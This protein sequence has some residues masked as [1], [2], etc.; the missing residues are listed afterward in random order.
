MSL[1]EEQFVEK[2]DKKEKYR[3][4]VNYWNNIKM[5]EPK[6]LS[7]ISQVFPH[8]TMHDV[9]HSIAILDSIE[10]FLGP[11]IITKLSVTDLW[12]LLCST[13]SHDI[14]MYI[15]GD[16][17]QKCFDSEEFHQFVLKQK[18]DT[19]SPLNKYAVFYDVDDNNKLRYNNC[20]LSL[21][22][23][24]SARFLL[25]EY[26]RNK[27]A[28]RSKNFIDSG[29]SVNQMY[30]EIKRLISITAE[31]CRLHSADFSEVMKFYDLENGIGDYCHPRFVTCML[32]IGDLLD[33]DS[34]RVSWFLLKHLSSS[35]PENSLTH[36]EKNFNVVHALVTPEKVD[37]FAECTDCNVA[38]EMDK[39]FSWI[40][41]E[42]SN[43]RNS[44]N[45]ISPVPEAKGYPMLG[46]L[47][48]KLIG[49]Y[50]AIDNNFKPKFEIDDE[51]AIKILQGSGLYSNK[52]DCI[53]EI[54]QNAV[55]A[56]YLRI[57]LER[58]NEFAE[59]KLDEGFKAFL[60][61]CKQPE[62]QIEVRCKK[63]E[64]EEIN[65]KEE[66]VN[67]DKKKK[68]V[69]HFE[70][71]DHGI[72]LRKSDLKYLLKI[73]SGKNNKDKFDIIKKMPEYAKPSGIF[74][75]GFQSIFLIAE[76]VNIKSRYA[77]SDEVIDV[78]VGTPLK[79]GFALLKTKKNSFAD[80]GTL[81][82]FDLMENISNDETYLRYDSYYNCFKESYDFLR[83][84]KC[85]LEI[86]RILNAV[87]KVVESSYLKI[88]C[89]GDGV[90]DV[91]EK[92]EKRKYKSIYEDEKENLIVEISLNCEKRLLRLGDGIFVNEGINLLYR[93]EAVIDHELSEY[94]KFL[95]LNINILSGNS[96]EILS[97]SRN[98]LK[99][100]YANRVKESIIKIII[101]WLVK[102][103]D[104][105]NS[106]DKKIAAL[107][108]EYYGKEGEYEEKRK[109]W[110]KYKI[111]DIT[112]GKKLKY[113]SI[114]IVSD[115]YYA[116]K[117]EGKNNDPKQKI[118]EYTFYSEE[119]QFLGYVLKKYYKY[120]MHY[121]Q[122]PKKNGV[123]DGSCVAIEFKKDSKDSIDWEYWLRE[124]RRRKCRS[125][126][127]CYDYKKIEVKDINCL[128]RHSDPMNLFE[129]V[130]YPKTVCPYV[131]KDD[132]L[133]WDCSDKV[134]QW[135]RENNI[136]DKVTEDEI[137][138]EY[139]KMR[140]D[141]EKI[142]K[143]LNDE[144]DKKKAK[145]EKDKEK[146]EAKLK[147]S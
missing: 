52:F 41:D 58:M 142:V 55:D 99:I 126:M 144:V 33:F 104:E 14:G 102:Y 97:V 87:D 6:I 10:G 63:R 118:M 38:F 111:D 64:I 96:D 130:S 127:P 95:G 131:V 91:E 114:T 68:Y 101:Q 146:K 98:A 37:V 123:H 13:Y 25:A 119:N 70:I 34:S 17:I 79:G 21:E 67:K 40:R 31:I 133:E 57:Y 69:W 42:M 90:K 76:K 60:N 124:Y 8:Y 84:K 46:K 59:K 49:G 11:N 73:G 147:K 62:Y 103:W 115:R 78:D 82:S 145:E 89:Y 65:E 1:I 23:Y 61:I 110:K 128:M 85:D 125:L 113:D 121:K 116:L 30:S 139:E 93:N 43:Q 39:W 48:T 36:N 80:K 94:I 112:F 47:E 120:G 117:K 105:F 137:K 22:S 51:K 74:G 53:R 140:K 132:K 108:I 88:C 32:R 71:Q 92:K 83:N 141:F 136:D 72:G 2:T 5:Q 50:D 138:N 122:Y 107:F 27:H 134:I 143:K 86:A 109:L 28:E 20:H 3:V 24:N 35:I 9:S 106:E 12:L 19:K 18:N 54:L 77:F 16:E 45:E 44:W 56:T 66:G 7:C 26:F 75:I 15:M 29:N 100:E 4:L 129:K 135:V 81:I